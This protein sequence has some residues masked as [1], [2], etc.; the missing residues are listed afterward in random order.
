[1]RIV[2]SSCN[3]STSTWHDE[4]DVGSKL[5]SSGVCYLRFSYSFRHC[6]DVV[7]QFTVKIRLHPN[8]DLLVIPL[9]YVGK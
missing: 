6:L 3:S 8:K 5:N 4:D 9:S 2:L 1:V 7:D